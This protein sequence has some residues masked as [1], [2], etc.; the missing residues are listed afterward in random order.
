[1]AKSKKA[2]APAAL[3]VCQSREETQGAIRE[4]GDVQRELI[5]IETEIND[6][7]AKI[8]DEKKSEIDALNTRINTL[9]SGIQLWCEAHRADLTGHG[10]KT[11]NLVTGEVSW[12]QRPPSVSIRQ[13]DKVIE[14]L[15]ALH[16][17]RF[18]REKTEVNKEAILAEPA[19]V[20]GVAGITV[21]TGVEDF[22]V[23]PFEI[24]VTP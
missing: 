16:L 17:A 12:R 5:R 3:Y 4:L 2:K 8:T 6:A 13:Q 9:T 14:T 11:A 10:G 23:T 15:K 7:I 21:V 19:A 20:A 22:S 1:M 18:L 24:E